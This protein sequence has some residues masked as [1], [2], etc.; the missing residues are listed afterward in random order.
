M[1]FGVTG[2]NGFLASYLL[3]ALA[4]ARPGDQILGIARRKPA[5]ELA[6]VR[7]QSELSPVDVLFHLAGSRGIAASLQNPLEDLKSNVV[8]TLEV[9]EAMRSGMASILVLASSCAVYGAIEGAAGED[10][11]PTP[12]SPYGLSKLM[13]EQYALLSHRRDNLDIRIA[14]IGNPYGPGQ[15]RL[16]IYELAKRAL[17]EG[18]PLRLRGDGTEIRD[19]IHAADVAR[20]LILLS[21]RGRPGN[22]YNVGSGKPTSLL[23]IAATIARAAG[24]PPE[25]VQA[26]GQAEPGKVPVFYPDVSKLTTLG[27]NAELSIEEGIEETVRWVRAQE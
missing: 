12:M 25:A 24:L 9:L 5:S 26:D 19:F 6:G 13:A 22:I 2:A 10:Q 11:P 18:A 16:A 7:Y 27:F 4:L 23:D 15:K 1:R 3:K 17:V 21:S 8:L 20:A 14:R